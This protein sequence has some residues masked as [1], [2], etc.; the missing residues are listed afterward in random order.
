MR[1]Y[2]NFGRKCPYA[3]SP[4]SQ[5]LFYRLYTLYPTTPFTGLDTTQHHHN[6]T[7]PQPITT[8]TSTNHTPIAQPHT[9]PLRV[10]SD[11]MRQNR[12][13][14]GSLGAGMLASVH[15]VDVHEVDL[16]A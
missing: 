14:F 16:R 9:P 8:T 2:W 1:V 12:Q 10:D 6:P 7:S 4:Y 11:E 5:S 13:V 3:L 15:E